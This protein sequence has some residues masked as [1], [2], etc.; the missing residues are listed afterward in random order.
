[1]SM[2]LAL[3]LAVEEV[4]DEMDNGTVEPVR[5]LPLS[6]VEY[7]IACQSG[8]RYVIKGAQSQFRG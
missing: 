1:M 5:I 7:I 8:Q 2:S 6:P 4:N 3:I